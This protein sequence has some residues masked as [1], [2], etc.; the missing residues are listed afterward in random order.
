MVQYG[1]RQRP[2]FPRSTPL[3]VGFRSLTLPVLHLSP[4]KAE[5]KERRARIRLSAL[6]SQLSAFP[7]A[8]TCFTPFR[9]SLNAIVAYQKVFG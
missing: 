9:G 5:S 6:R 7:D 8:H 1:E 3:A 2:G 4:E